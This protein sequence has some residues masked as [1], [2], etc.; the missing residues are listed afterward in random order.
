MIKFKGH[1]YRAAVEVQRDALDEDAETMV[2]L[3]LS[4]SGKE[5]GTPEYAELEKKFIAR[6]LEMFKPNQDPSKRINVA[7]STPRQMEQYLVHVE[8]EI[9]QMEQEDYVQDPDQRY[10]DL[11]TLYNKADEI[12]TYLQRN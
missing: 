9:E 5:P 1:L 10:E 4:K 12:R 11:S 3:W 6:A 8:Q 7:T 2:A